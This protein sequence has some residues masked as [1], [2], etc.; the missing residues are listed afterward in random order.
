MVPKITVAI[1]TLN[2]RDYIRE[3]IES[4]RNQ[5]LS[6]I[7]ILV[8]DAN[9]TDGTRE[10]LE[11]YAKK[12][13]RIRILDDTA[14]STGFA[15]NLAID[16]A[17]APFYAVVEA[18]D[19][20]EP[21]M[22]EKLYG[23]A[24]DTGADIVK[25]SFDTFIGD[26]KERFF[27]PKSIAPGGDFDKIICPSDYTKAFR[28]TMYEWLGLYKVSF[29]KEFDVRHNETPGAA[30][31][32]IG[33]WFL[34]FAFARNVIVSRDVLYHYRCDNPNASVKN[35]KKVF[36]TCVEYEYI[37]GRLQKDEVIWNKVKGAFYREY[38]HSNMAA[39]S[40]L[41]E[42]LRPSL[43][44]R[45]KE[46]LSAARINDDID[47]SCFDDKELVQ[48]NILLDTED[49]DKVML[50]KKRS[51]DNSL[52]KLIEGISGAKDIVIYGA[53]SFGANLQY[54]LKKERLKASAFADGNKKLAGKEL[55][56]VMILE[57]ESCADRY[58]G[59]EWL[60]ANKWCA[61]DM[62]KYLISDLGVNADRIRICD[63]EDYM[64][65]I[66]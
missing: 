20:V 61:N 30:F 50:E 48:L 40:R 35:P 17:K 46:E 36:D 66:I 26:G 6:D 32:D 27:F 55:N 31:Q 12:D 37:Q 47:N 43:S 51:G 10:I 34:G 24:I 45:M 60:I 53:G 49:F 22:L 65:S 56:G 28:W 41:D 7:E 9:S 64:E 33:F 44:A 38:F 52:H 63:V 59:A 13:S 21:D 39:Y 14:K 18:D 2:C 25:G 15:K 62:K 1:P 29:L 57:P 19:Y 4:V 3:C 42:T 8:I 11:E 58:S 16:E 23:T 54:L 5:S